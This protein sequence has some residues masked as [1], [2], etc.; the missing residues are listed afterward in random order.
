MINSRLKNRDIIRAFKLKKGRTVIAGFDI[1]KK[2]HPSHLAVFG[3]VKALVREKV[4]DKESL[5]WKDVLVQLC[6]KYMD[7]WDYTDQIEYL[8][9]AIFHFKID[10]LFYDNVPEP[11]LKALK[12]RASC[13][14]RWSRYRSRSRKNMAWPR[15]WTLRSH[16]AKY[17]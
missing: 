2:T 4:D 16:P 17:N 11:N 13:R 9:K 1:G 7:G 5:V 6:S 10:K 15:R 8:K 3:V 14:Q 12:K